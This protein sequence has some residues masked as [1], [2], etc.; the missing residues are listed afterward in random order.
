M[1]RAVAPY[2]PAKA[3]SAPG[4]ALVFSLLRGPAR[5]GRGPNRGGGDGGV[6]IV[7]RGTALALPGTRF[8]AFTIDGWKGFSYGVPPQ[9]V[10]VQ[11]APCGRLNRDE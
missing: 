3:S 2:S 7:G 10:G 9:I 4:L 5:M 11:W 1:L 6:V 8:E